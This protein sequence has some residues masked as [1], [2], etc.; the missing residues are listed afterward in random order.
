[1]R[2]RSLRRASMRSWFADVVP[3]LRVEGARSGKVISEAEDGMGQRRSGE[4]G[5]RWSGVP[6]DGGSF[7]CIVA[8]GLHT[9]I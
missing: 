7:P 1:M 5:V 4:C 2:W 6:L 8:P 3:L 9:K